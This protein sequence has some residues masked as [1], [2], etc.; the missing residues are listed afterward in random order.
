[1]EKYIIDK[2]MLESFLEQ[3]EQ[4]EKKYGIMSIK[5]VGIY[6]MALHFINY[7]EEFLKSIYELASKLKK[8]DLANKVYR[9]TQV[10]IIENIKTAIKNGSI[11]EYLASLDMFT[12]CDLKVSIDLIF[13]KFYKD[14]QNLL[15]LLNAS[16]DNALSKET[17]RTKSIYFY[18]L[19]FK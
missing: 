8:D 15:P 6:Y 3:L 19:N 2:E 13:S 17:R 7:D 4:I 9:I 16:T 18:L 1:M 14:T 12:K 11:D 10:K 5:N